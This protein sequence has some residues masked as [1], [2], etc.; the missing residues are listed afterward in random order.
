MTQSAGKELERLKETVAY[1]RGRIAETPQIALILGSGLSGV[2]KTLEDEKRFPWAEIPNFPKP[3]VAGHIGEWLFSKLENKKVLIQRGRVHYYEGYSMREIVFPVRV[4]KLLGV[5][6]LVITNAA[7]AI[8][9]KFKV[10]DFVLIRD[11]INMIP[12]NPL[13][14]ENFP[15]GPRFPDLSEAYSPKLREL[16]KRAARSEKIDLK[17]GVYV[18]TPGPMFETPAEIQA[19]KRMGA[20]LVGMSTVPEVIAARH[21]G[22]EILGISVVT[23]MAAGIEPGARLTHEEVLQVTKRREKDLSKLLRAILRQ[24]TS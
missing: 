9:E 7:G 18:A 10:G 4:M 15:F 11:H 14:G 6:K 22:M 23:N 19:Y 21:C 20:D 5:E 3:T 8:N 16:A 1:L 12:D 2:L 24:L 17:E 13:R